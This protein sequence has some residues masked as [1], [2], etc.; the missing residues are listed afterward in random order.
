MEQ[1]HCGQGDS[2]FWSSHTEG[3]RPGR[4]FCPCVSALAQRDTFSFPQRSWTL[5]PGLEQKVG[6][7]RRALGTGGSRRQESG[8]PWGAGS[9]R[10]QVGSPFPSAARSL[11]SGSSCGCGHDCLPYVNGVCLH[12]RCGTSP[13]GC[14]TAG[15]TSVG[16]VRWRVLGAR[17]AG[18]LPP[19][20]L[21]GDS[22]QPGPRRGNRARSFDRGRPGRRG[23]RDGG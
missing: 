23:A 16:S 15:G 10:V 4:R 17:W 13:Q 12:G 9:G 5:R 22:V 18:R 19:A 21:G 14:G 6:P 7:H 1:L 11:W 20:A 2:A 3:W 8:A